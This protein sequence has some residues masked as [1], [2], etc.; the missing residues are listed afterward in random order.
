MIT[1]AYIALGLSFLNVLIAIAAEGQPRAPVGLS[2]V[3]HE[4]LYF[5]LFLALASRV[6]GW[7]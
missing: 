6:L 2:D 3:L 4:L 7:R 5:L 1:V